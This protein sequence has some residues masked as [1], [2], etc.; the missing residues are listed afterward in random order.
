MPNTRTTVRS[1]T[2][3]RYATVGGRSGGSAV[4]ALEGSSDV[5]HQCV[6]ALISRGDA[7]FVGRTKDGSAILLRVYSEGGNGEWYE[8]SSSG[9]I[10]TLYA[11]TEAAKAP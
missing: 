11:I 7:L 8:G 2:D 5:L 9:L 1:A 10:S 3:N 4:S 6:S